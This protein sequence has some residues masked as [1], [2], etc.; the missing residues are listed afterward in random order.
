[1]TIRIWLTRGLIGLAFAALGAGTAVGVIFWEPWEDDGG[2]VQQAEPTTPPRLTAQEAIGLVANNCRSSSVS[3]SISSH[4]TAAYD[5]DGKWTVLV[6]VGEVHATWTVDETTSAVIPLGANWLDALC[7][8]QLEAS[9][10]RDSGLR[11]DLRR[12]LGR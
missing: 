5:G 8:Q 1:M 9:E 6:V 7:R 10:G 11:R 2:G 12:D 4:A 3:F